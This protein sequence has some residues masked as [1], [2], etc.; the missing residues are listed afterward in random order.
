MPNINPDKD[1]GA[2]ELRINKEYASLLPPLPDSEYEA[3]KL[4]VKQNGQH[5][6]IE[7]NRDG[8]ILDGIILDGHHRFKACEELKIEPKITIHDFKDLSA[9]GSIAIRKGSGWSCKRCF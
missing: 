9:A 2:N 6:P 3:L 4:S 8:I 1:D 7:V 5:D